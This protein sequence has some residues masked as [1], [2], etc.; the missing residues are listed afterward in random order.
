MKTIAF[1]GAGLSSAVLA[2][3]LAD[4]GRFRCVLFDKRPHLGGNCHTARDEATGVMLHTYGP[5]IFHTSNKAVWDYVNRFTEFGAFVNRVRAVTP[6]GIF[7]LPVNLMTLNQFF[8]KNMTPK[9]A[10]AFVR[11]LGAPFRTGNERTFEEVAL[12]LVGEALYRNF[13]HG[14]TKK[15]WG[16]EPT[17]LPGSIIKRLPLRF[18]YRDDY[19]QSIYQGIPLHG[20]TPMIEKIVDHP[21]IEVRLGEGLERDPVV[22]G[23]EFDH[24]FWSGPIDACYGFRHGRLS[25]RT[26]YWSQERLDGDAQGTVCLNYTAEDVPYTRKIEYKHY[27]PWESHEKTLVSTEFSKATGPAD[28]PYYPIRSDRDMATLRH[29]VEEAGRETKVSFI[30]RLG[31]YRYLDMHMV[32]EESLVY[33]ERLL[34]AGEGAA[35]PRFSIADEKVLA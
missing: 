9:E 13:F 4:T 17:E 8:G 22:N 33:A 23:S 30:G 2:R 29:Y 15:Q 26:V 14:Y 34:A 35:W 25:Y 28:D 18:N 5:H 27:T 24:L 19:Y 11:E 12:S 16:C 6:K 32:V 21:A 20:Y 1:A 7:S 3:Q 31:T 10:E